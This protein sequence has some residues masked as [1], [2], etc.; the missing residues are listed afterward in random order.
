MAK[1]ASSRLKMLSISLL[2]WERSWGSIETRDRSDRPAQDGDDD[3]IGEDAETRDRRLR[4]HFEPK[5]NL[6]SGEKVLD[7]D[8]HIER[9]LEV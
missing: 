3:E 6:N 5:G 1:R 2:N 9:V 8:N 4:H 7:R